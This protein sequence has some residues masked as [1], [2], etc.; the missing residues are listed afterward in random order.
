MMNNF[1]A[2]DE[3]EGHYISFL[4]CILPSIDMD[5]CGA[6]F[7]FQFFLHFFQEAIKD[8]F[9]SCLSLLNELIPYSFS[10]EFKG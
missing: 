2:K 10:K 7:F 3:I 9:I 6:L 4:F 5:C 8:F 1:I